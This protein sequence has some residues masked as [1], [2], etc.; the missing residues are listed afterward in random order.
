MRSCEKTQQNQNMLKNLMNIQNIMF[1]LSLPY[2]KNQKIVK[3][4]TIYL[5]SFR[6]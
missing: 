4:Q 2:G 3:C 1:G 5:D 6:K